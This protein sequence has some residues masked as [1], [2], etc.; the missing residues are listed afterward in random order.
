MLGGRK[1]EGRQVIGLEWERCSHPFHYM[2]GY[3]FSQNPEGSWQK[4]WG[5]EKAP[6]SGYHVSP[7]SETELLGRDPGLASSNRRKTGAAHGHCLGP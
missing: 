4:E 5:R 6:E 2:Q 1:Q 7:V 3:F